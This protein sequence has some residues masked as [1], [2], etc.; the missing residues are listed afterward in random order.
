LGAQVL[1]FNFRGVGQSEGEHANGLGE[2][3]DLLAVVQ[4]CQQNWPHAPVWLAGFS[5]GAVVAAM[6]H[7]QIA[8]QRL[9]LVAPAVDM[10]PDVIPIKIKTQDWLLIQGEQDEIVS[11]Q[12]V[13]DWA[14]QQEIMPK[15]LFVA[16]A[17]HFFHG[18]LNLIKDGILG[19]WK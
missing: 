8:P 5:F 15:K 2:Q 18:K 7:E 6:A 11:S 12:S 17:G 4:W 13:N 3:D 19:E 14:R 10:Y 9:V 1:R 16:E